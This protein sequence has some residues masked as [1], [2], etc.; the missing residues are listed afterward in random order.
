MGVPARFQ[1][2]SFMLVKKLIIDIDVEGIRKLR[3]ELL[4]YWKPYDPSS[5]SVESVLTDRGISEDDIQLSQH[6]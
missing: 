4:P 3:V 5:P 2:L 6:G 1:S